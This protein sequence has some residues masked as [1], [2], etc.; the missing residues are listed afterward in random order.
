M[1]ASRCEGASAKEQRRSPGADRPHALLVVL[2]VDDDGLVLTNTLAMLEDLG[3]TAHGASTGNAALEVL[4][5]DNSI[6]LVITDQVMPRMTGLQ[7]AEKIKAE[8]P[9][10]PVILATGFAEIPSGSSYLQG[11]PSHLVRQSLP[12]R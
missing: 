2:A 12:R 4:R 10:L 1:V 9:T 8:W 3:H 7:L 5:Q 6:D 11:F